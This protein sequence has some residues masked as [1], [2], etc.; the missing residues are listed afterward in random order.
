MSVSHHL[1]LH[2]L[3]LYVKL[4]RLLKLQSVRLA[5]RAK[6]KKKLQ[7]LNSRAAAKHSLV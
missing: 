1:A 5:R 3:P 6:L 4:T 7:K 2:Q